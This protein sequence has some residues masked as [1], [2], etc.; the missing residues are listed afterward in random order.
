MLA[1]KIYIN[2]SDEIEVVIDKVLSASAKVVILS[3][4]KFSQM[5]VLDENLALLKSRVDIASKTIRIESVDDRVL[6][7]AN[8]IG[9]EANNPFFIKIDDK[10]G[11]AMDITSKKIT[12]DKFVNVPVT[13]VDYK[14]DNL[15]K[16]NKD[17]EE[18]IE[19][20]A[21]AELEKKF[22]PIVDNLDSKVK[23]SGILGIIALI[24]MFSGFLSY[25]AFFIMPK[26]D[27]KI[28]AEKKSFNLANVI[29]VDKTLRSVD[30]LNL[31]IPGQVF[32]EKKNI[33]LTFEANG[34]KQV[35]KKSSGKVT[36]YNAYSS[37]KQVLVSSTRLQT[38]DGKT[39]RLTKTITVPGAKIE[40][41]K[42][43]P[44]SIETE[45]TADVAGVEYNIGP[46][47]R[48]TIPGL[49]GTPRY[50]SFYAES[51]TA[52]SG[53]YVGELAY[54]IDSDIK[55]G[56]DAVL[57]ALEGNAKNILLQ[58]IPSD[59]KVVD[60][61][62]SFSLVKQTVNGDVDDRGF[63]SIY[64]EGEASAMAFKENDLRSIFQIKMEEAYGTDFE[65]RDQVLTYLNATPDISSGK[66]R[67]SLDF[68]AQLSRQV[69]V[70]ELRSK[71]LGKS[72]AELKALL[73]S[74]SGLDSA[75]ISLWP[76]WVRSVP[77]KESKVNIMVE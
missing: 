28:V 59:F 29:V 51:K 75:Q 21:E 76:F 32:T 34:K 15:L 48:F 14:N 10:Q 45:V 63:F 27:I 41:G 67:L 25:T 9:I 71:I 39:F 11:R 31:K 1:K 3:V 43:V 65:I 13:L 17:Y 22:G 23:P 42:I 60:G 73:V 56:K 54:P 12:K 40:D 61:S 46:I 37:V 49:K 58:K 24:L 20:E 35:H 50:S 62:V 18:N 68:K 53:G 30:A 47:A 8:S 64:A 55:K 69:K 70:E 44:S 2:K 36:L 66:L 74:F 6:S 26:A 7:L 33:T 38:P 5:A 52:F 77:S 16:I 57:S 19:A 4:P 72:E